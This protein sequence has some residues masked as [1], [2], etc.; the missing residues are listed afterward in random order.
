VSRP[1]Q[2]QPTVTMSSAPHAALTRDGMSPAVPTTS[3]SARL[4]CLRHVPHAMVDQHHRCWRPFLVCERH[5]E[6]AHQDA[7]QLRVCASQGVAGNQYC[8]CHSNPPITCALQ[9]LSSTPPHTR[10]ISA[11]RQDANLTV[12]ALRD[13]R[14]HCRERARTGGARIVH[15]EIC[16]ASALPQ[17]DHCGVLTAEDGDVFE[18]VGRGACPVTTRRRSS[19]TTAGRRGTR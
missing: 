14:H 1:P 12:K 7:A 11:P 13:E 15:L 2:P 9:H 6:A 4:R 8:L 19:C 17:R 10:Q 5:K 16:Q 3:P 18:G